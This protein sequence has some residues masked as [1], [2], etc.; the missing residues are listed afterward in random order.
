MSEG[1]NNETN[2][3]NTFNTHS[4][5]LSHRGSDGFPIIKVQTNSS[6]AIKTKTKET[7]IKKKNKKF[8]NPIIQEN[9]AQSNEN[10]N[11][12]HN[13]MESSTKLLLRSLKSSPIQIL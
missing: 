5:L 11:L 10:N 7:S 12:K 13:A 8:E 6:S 2:Q 4:T 9:Y 1:W 3:R